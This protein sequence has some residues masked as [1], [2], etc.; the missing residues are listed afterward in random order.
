MSDVN[1]DSIKKLAKVYAA[2]YDVRRQL[3]ADVS[4]KF[5]RLNKEL[6]KTANPAPVVGGGILD[7]LKQILGSTGL[8]LDNPLHT[9][10]IGSLLAG[11]AGA[12][13]SFRRPASSRMTGV[14]ASVAA[15]LGGILGLSAPILFNAVKNINSQ[16]KNISA[17]TDTKGIETNLSKLVGMNQ[18]QLINLARESGI[19]PAA[20]IEAVGNLKPT[21]METSLGGL[22]DFAENVSNYRPL[23]AMT[24]VAS[25]A[26]RYRNRPFFALTNA[27][28][29][30]YWSNFD[31][32]NPAVFTGRLNAWFNRSGSITESQKALVDIFRENPGF[33]RLVSGDL[34]KSTSKNLP[35]TIENLR[36][37]LHSKNNPALTG[38]VARDIRTGLSG[39]RNIPAAT[40]NP[41]SSAKDYAQFTTADRLANPQH[42]PAHAFKTGPGA[43]LKRVISKSKL[44]LGIGGLALSA[45][46]EP[47]IVSSARKRLADP[48]IRSAFGNPNLNT[49]QTRTI[50][51]ALRNFSR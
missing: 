51:S 48:A 22:G 50:E 8:S 30:K 46:L 1:L 41:F 32:K 37:I 45:V 40:V 28:K 13:G 21:D 23:T 44:P 4:S 15:G 49:D 33:A 7:N 27:G 35:S 18:S 10:I 39:L 20:L 47:A 25:G 31:T 9:A 3:N 2:H 36:N 38:D 24:G 17:A 5:S 42:I 19:Q 14:D 16:N 29:A 11:S 43:T 34:A 26:L 6:H 12:V